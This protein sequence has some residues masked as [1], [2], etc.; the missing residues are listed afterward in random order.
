[1]CNGVVSCELFC[2]FTLVSLVAVESCDKPGCSRL[3]ANNP[4]NIND[5]AIKATRTTAAQGITNDVPTKSNRADNA[6]NPE[7]KRV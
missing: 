7:K 4:N 5:K 1:M 6:L 2:L 3:H